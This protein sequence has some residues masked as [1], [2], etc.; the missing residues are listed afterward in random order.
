MAESFFIAVNAV[1]PFFC[2]LA[3]GY[4]AKCLGKVDTPFLDRLTK[5]IFSIMFPFMTF[6]NIYA[7][8]RDAVPSR[9]L[10][11]LSPFSSVGMQKGTPGFPR[12]PE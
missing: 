11:V 5:L 1:I 4:G 6:N 9:M 3:L 2:Y 10:L 7:A 12:V 8:S